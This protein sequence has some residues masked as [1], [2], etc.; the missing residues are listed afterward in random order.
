MGPEIKT[1]SR[2]VYLNRNYSPEG[3]IIGSTLTATVFGIDA[4]VAAVQNNPIPPEHVLAFPVVLATAMWGGMTMPIVYRRMMERAYEADKRAKALEDSIPTTTEHMGLTF[5]NAPHLLL[6]IAPNLLHPGKLLNNLRHPVGEVLHTKH[7]QYP[8]EEANEVY[9]VEHKLF[10]RL[11]TVDIVKRDRFRKGYL[12]RLRQLFD[13][14]F[15][16]GHA[17]YFPKPFRLV[18][19]TFIDD[20]NSFDVDSHV[21]KIIAKV[22]G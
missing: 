9:A 6:M 2:P 19:R 14:R 5:K 10:G 15:Y 11:V 3:G 20:P 7:V 4:F 16:Y 22:R 12:L 8:V 13:R 17:Q 21:K 18:D 1:L